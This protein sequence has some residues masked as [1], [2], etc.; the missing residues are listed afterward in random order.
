MCKSIPIVESWHH[1]YRT[2]QEATIPYNY[3]LSDNKLFQEATNTLYD[4]NM[5]ETN[6]ELFLKYHM[7]NKK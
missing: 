6:T 5:I 4:K 1:T 7:I 2:K 3:I